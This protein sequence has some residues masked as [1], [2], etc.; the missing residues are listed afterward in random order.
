MTV[1]MVMVVRTNLMMNT[2]K[3]MIATKAQQEDEDV[4]LVHNSPPHKAVKCCSTP[5]LTSGRNVDMDASM[6]GNTNNGLAISP[7]GMMLGDD[8]GS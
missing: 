5:L 4:I 3:M 6:A 1:M 8:D 2:R 7:P